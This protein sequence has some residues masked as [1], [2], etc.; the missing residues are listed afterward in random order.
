MSEGVGRPTHFKTGGC[1]PETTQQKPELLKW[2]PMHMMGSSAPVPG[3][4]LLLPLRQEGLTTFLSVS[5]WMPRL[6]LPPCQIQSFQWIQ[7]GHLW[8]ED[9]L[10]LSFLQKAW[11]TPVHHPATLHK[12]KLAFYQGALLLA[13][14]GGQRHLKAKLEVSYLWR[15]SH[16]ASI[17]LHWSKFWHTSL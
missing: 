14:P 12:H 4:W 8:Q 9:F 6:L 1:R 11:I 15:G 5:L 13:L 17:W 3:H 10:F 2:L 16:Q 7:R